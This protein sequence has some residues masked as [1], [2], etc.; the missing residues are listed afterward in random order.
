MWTGWLQDSGLELE[1]ATP[2]TKV[3]YTDDG[4]LLHASRM[5]AG[6]TVDYRFVSLAT[7]AGGIPMLCSLKPRP[8]FDPPRGLELG[9]GSGYETT[10]YAAVYI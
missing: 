6:C 4:S 9:G 3:S 8:P 10:G 2:G 5:V 7:R 1:S